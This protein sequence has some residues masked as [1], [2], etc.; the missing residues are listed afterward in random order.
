MTIEEARL[1]IDR[2]VV[3]SN[4][5]KIDLGQTKDCV[6]DLVRA[7]NEITIGISVDGKPATLVYTAEDMRGIAHKALK[8]A[9]VR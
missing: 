4:L 3:E 6:A 9:G 5:L 2:L 7:L 8:S 1:E